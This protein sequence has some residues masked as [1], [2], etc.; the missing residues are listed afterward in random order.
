MKWIFFLMLLSTGTWEK[1]LTKIQNQIEVFIFIHESCRISQFYT[2][3]LKELHQE[4]ADEN[5]RFTGVFPSP[6]TKE[7]AMQEFKEK[8]DLPFSLYFDEGQKITN[9]MGASLTPE[10]VVYDKEQEKILYRGR[11]D[12]SYYRVGKRRNVTTSFELLTVLKKLK[13]GKPVDIENQP[14]IGCFIQKI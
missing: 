10:V 5:I 13:E 3:T 4:Y 12:N 1:E 11:I 2:L 6:S 8:Y 7:R 9:K 14:A